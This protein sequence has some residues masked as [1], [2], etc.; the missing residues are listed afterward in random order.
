[1]FLTFDLPEKCWDMFII[2]RKSATKKGIQND[3]TRPEINNLKLSFSPE[4]LLLNKLT[5]W[6]GGGGGP[7]GTVE[8][9]R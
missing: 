3:S 4:G 7:G 8:K 1:M 9:M 5:R 6:N 2:K